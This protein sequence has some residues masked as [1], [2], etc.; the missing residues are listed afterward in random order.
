[1]SKIRLCSSVARVSCESIYV[2]SN[3][4]I[5]FTSLNALTSLSTPSTSYASVPD[6]GLGQPNSQVIVTSVAKFVLDGSLYRYQYGV[7]KAIFN[8]KVRGGCCT[9][10]ISDKVDTVIHR[11]EYLLNNN[12]FGKY[13]LTK[14]N[15]EDFS[16]YCK[17]GL[18]IV[19]TSQMRSS[20]QISSVVAAPETL[21]G[22]VTI[23]ATATL[24]VAS[25]SVGAVLSAPIIPIT[26]LPIL[27]STTV[28]GGHL[29]DSG[30]KRR[31][32]DD[33]GVRNDVVKVRVEDLADTMRAK[34]FM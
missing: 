24:A 8:A 17:T 6:G 16:L 11:A 23:V 19:G 28:V 14:N 33:I 26:A 7:T 13:S 29:I 1:M 2:G 9:T 12:G 31:F 34:G 32:E 30:F 4:V 10:A 27:A 22:A 25:I 15:C 3:R 20:G 21:F 18:R 5:H